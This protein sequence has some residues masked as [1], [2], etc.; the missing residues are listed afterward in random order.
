MMGPRVMGFRY[1]IF[2]EGICSYTKYDQF[3][4]VK[5][6]KVANDAS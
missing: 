4:I 6:L 1:T 5:E 3:D 2:L